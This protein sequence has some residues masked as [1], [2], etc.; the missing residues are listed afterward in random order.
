MSWLKRKLQHTIRL[1][2]DTSLKTR[3]NNNNNND[4]NNYNI[5][6]IIQ[7]EKKKKRKKLKEYKQE[8]NKKK[9]TL[10]KKR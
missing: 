4:S 5:I 7:I 3:N 2:T 8:H 6:N 10:K 1:H 9:I